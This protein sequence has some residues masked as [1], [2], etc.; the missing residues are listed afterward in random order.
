MDLRGQGQ[1]VGTESKESQ[2]GKG[3]MASPTM[4]PSWPHMNL[5]IPPEIKH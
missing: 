3:H 4:D 1:E 2:E 5:E